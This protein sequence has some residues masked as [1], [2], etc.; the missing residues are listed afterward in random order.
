VAGQY[1]KGKKNTTQGVHWC[2]RGETSLGGKKERGPIKERL[3]RLKKSKTRGS[4]RTRK[5]TG[6]RG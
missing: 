3:W 1:E 2:N 4:D 6:K 5:R